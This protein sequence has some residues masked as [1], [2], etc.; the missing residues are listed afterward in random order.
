MPAPGTSPSPAR[1]N[2]RRASS[3]HREPPTKL[4][5]EAVAAAQPRC[6]PVHIP[7]TW[8]KALAVVPLALASL[9]SVITLL[10]LLRLRARVDAFWEVPAV[11]WFALGA[12]LLLLPLLWRRS[13]HELL[14]LYVIGHEL[15]HALAV[16]AS[17]GWVDWHESRIIRP[18]NAFIVAS[19]SNTFVTLAPYLLPFWAAIWTGLVCAIHHFRPLPQFE[20]V[21]CAGLGLFI[22]F[23]LLY[24]LWLS[25]MEQS[26]FLPNGLA[27]S[28]LL[29]LLVNVAWL[30]ALLVWG[31]PALGWHRVGLL[32][33]SSARQ[34][35]QLGRELLP[36]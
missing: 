25:T 9:V 5:V 27:F 10:R 36:V 29:I 7:V 16:Y 1:G 8:L 33:K 11:R 17:L 6:G 18:D 34:L 3:H 2:S 22:A 31:D 14:R 13:R 24:T 30:V 35:W 21:L 23:H 32:W 26:D 12:A 20:A 28:L 15:A 19:R 4:R